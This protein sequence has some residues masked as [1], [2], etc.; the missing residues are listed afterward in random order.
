MPTL[1]ARKVSDVPAPLRA[2]RAVRE[3]QQLYEGFIRQIGGDVGEL[4][5]GSGEQIRSLKV[6][7]RRAATRLNAELEIWDANDRVYFR[8]QA[9][10]R[11]GRP[12]KQA[13]VPAPKL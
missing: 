5:P 8:T 2:S 3:Q 13:K 11:R 7:L 6:R 12:S 4:E 1:T 9:Q 10:R